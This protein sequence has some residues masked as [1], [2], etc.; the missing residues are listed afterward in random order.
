M[1]DQRNY[2]VLEAVANELGS[3]LLYAKRQSWVV[4]STSWVY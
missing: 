1:S 4:H 3:P 2:E